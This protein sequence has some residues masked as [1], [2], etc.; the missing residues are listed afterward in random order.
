M[1]QTW[2]QQLT[3]TL[4]DMMLGGFWFW[5]LDL[6]WL[7]LNCW[8]ATDIFWHEL[9]RF[10]TNIKTEQ[11]VHGGRI[12]NAISVQKIVW[13]YEDKVENQNEKIF[14]EN[15]SAARFAY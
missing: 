5:S 14:N 11:I 9:F 15:K 10:Y 1:L 12:K 7:K 2:P 13:V 8:G 3:T 6:S 4:A